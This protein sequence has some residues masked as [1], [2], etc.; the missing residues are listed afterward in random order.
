MTNDNIKNRH[1]ISNKPKRKPRCIGDYPN[2]LQGL[3]TNKYG[4]TNLHSITGYRGA[5]YGAA[6]PVHI[7]TPEEIVDYANDNDLE[8][9]KS[10]LEKLK[11]CA[12]KS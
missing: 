1:K 7:Y 8:V 4:G 2:N 11:V 12:D 10:V 6:G 9:A 3:S 5:S